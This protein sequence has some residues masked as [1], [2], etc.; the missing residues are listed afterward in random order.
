[1]S[2][3][4]KLAGHVTGQ[5]RLDLT[6]GPGADQ[7]G[8]GR[9]EADR[10]PPAFPPPMSRL[11]SAF[12]TVLKCVSLLHV[13]HT[14]V[15]EF[16]ETKGESMLPTLNSHGDYVHV[17]KWYRNGRDVQMGDCV[18]LQKP[19]DS[20]RRVCKRITGMPGDYVL[21]DPSLAEEDTYPLHYKDTNGADPLDMYIKVPRGHVWVTG[22]NL[23]YSLDSRTYNVVPMG[24]ITGKVVAANDMNKPLW[25]EE[26]KILGFRKVGNTFV[27]AVQ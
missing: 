7:T 1:M 13:T 11:P 22:D 25:D 15:Y 4:S 27:D 21:V 23:P 24:L 6:T 8:Q 10:P 3:V 20:N 5:R 19:N 16:T 14:R 2:F 9:S 17:S 12:T 18:V 26:G